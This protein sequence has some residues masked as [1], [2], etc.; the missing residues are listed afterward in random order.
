MS[1]DAP[2]A[3]SEI[4]SYT[5]EDLRDAD[6]LERFAKATT[7]EMM[8]KLRQEMKTSSGKFFLDAAKLWEK[9]VLSPKTK[10]RE[11]K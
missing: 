5:A 3:P 8:V 10:S 6:K 11:E 1:E 4:D 7:R 2:A 9:L